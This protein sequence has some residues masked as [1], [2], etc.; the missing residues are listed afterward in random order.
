MFNTCRITC[1]GSSHVRG[2]ELLAVSWRELNHVETGGK[3]EKYK[4]P[5][6]GWICIAIYAIGIIVCLVRR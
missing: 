4:M 6:I 1:V 5:I 2:S 3:M